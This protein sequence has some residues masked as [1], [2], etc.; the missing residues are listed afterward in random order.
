MT[1]AA[2]KPEDT[3]GRIW[4]NVQSALRAQTSRRDFDTWLRGAR[5]QT[6]RD[7]V[8]V[9]V[10]PDVRVK[11]GIERRFLSVLRDQLTAYIDEPIRVRI[12]IDGVPLSPV[13]SPARA[14]DI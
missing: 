10:V 13:C 1:P 8:A 3:L 2:F 7:G 14:R 6:V 12:V 9:I 5:L 4:D 11:D